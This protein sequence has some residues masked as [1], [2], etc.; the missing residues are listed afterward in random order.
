LPES[1]TK[2]FSENG[3]VHSFELGQSGEV[4]AVLIEQ[5]GR[6]IRAKKVE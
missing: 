5:G 2:Y 1:E 3:I 6:T 4:A